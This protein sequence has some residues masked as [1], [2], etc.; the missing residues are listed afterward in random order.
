MLYHDGMFGI[1]FFSLF[2]SSD[3]WKILLTIILIDFEIGL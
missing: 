3:G 2:F 1:V